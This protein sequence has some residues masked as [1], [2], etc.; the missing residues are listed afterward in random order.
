VAMASVPST[1]ANDKGNSAADQRHRGVLNWVWTPTILKSTDPVARILVNGWQVSGIFT[2]ASPQS[3][4]PIVLL[5]G[6][7]F[8][9]INMAY[10]NSLNGSGGW[11]RVPFQ[12]VNSLKLGTQ[13]NVNGRVGKTFSFTERIR[14]TLAFEAFNLLNNQYTTGVNNVAYIATSGVLRPAPGVGV[15]NASAAYPY[16]STARRAQISVRFDW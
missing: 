13:Y 11:N 6:Q 10:L 4:T 7:Q 2:V 12:A 1:C 16:G 5:S 3:V 15:A 14:A 8:S 9:G